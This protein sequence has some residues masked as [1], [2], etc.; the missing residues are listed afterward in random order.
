ML[1]APVWLRHNIDHCGIQQ[2]SDHQLCES[3]CFLR[4]MNVSQQT[5]LCNELI[6]Y[7]RRRSLLNSV[8]ET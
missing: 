3:E 5:V 8:Q 6:G 2:E 4:W 7:M 1:L